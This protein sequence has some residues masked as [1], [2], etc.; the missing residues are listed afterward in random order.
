MGEKSSNLTR[1]RF[2]L[3]GSAALAAT[4][5]LAELAVVKAAAAENKP[6]AVKAVPTTLAKGTKVY[7]IGRG[8]VGC[9]TCRTLCPAKAI[10][11][12]DGANEIDQNA[13]KHCGTCYKECPACVITETVV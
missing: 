9:H 6:F 3:A 11:L 7:F 12:G 2:M 1:R 4:P 13:C 5:L 8:C 10:H